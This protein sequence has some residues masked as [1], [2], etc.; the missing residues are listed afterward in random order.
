MYVIKTWKHSDHEK[1][2]IYI[3]E[4]EMN[5]ILTTNRPLSPEDNL[6]ADVSF[7]I[8]ESNGWAADRSAHSLI[9]KNKTFEN[10]CFILWA[11]KK[12]TCQ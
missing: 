5:K 2:H 11:L 6:P 9:S 3:F 1:T 4:R 12:L 8:T 10:L 7:I